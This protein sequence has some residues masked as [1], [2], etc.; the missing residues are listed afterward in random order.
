M[1]HIRAS[2]HRLSRRKR[3]LCHLLQSVIA[4]HFTNDTLH[5]GQ[6]IPPIGKTLIH[7]GA[8]VPCS[9]GLHASEHPFDALQYAPGPRLHLVKLTGGLISHGDPIDKWVGRKRTIIASIDATEILRYSARQFALSVTHLWNPP[10]IVLDY[11][12][13]GDDSLRTA[14]W[15]AAWA[16]ARD[17]AR[18]A[19]WDA[20]WAAAWAAARDAAWAAAWDAARDAARD[21]AWDAA[22]DAARD[23]AWA[24][25]WD[26]ARDAAWAAARDAALKEYRNLFASLTDAEFHEYL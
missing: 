26:A 19:A 3:T 8:V 4:Y 2:Y 24:A 12:V 13:T 15:D 16:A 22:R 7:N 5:N 17:A 14:A 25:A 21:A 9:S 20:A 10:D 6:P 11:L 18:D 23:A 1:R